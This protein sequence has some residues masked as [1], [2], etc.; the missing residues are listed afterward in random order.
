MQ[1]RVAS[2]LL[3]HRA[4]E[5][6]MTKL[7]AIAVAFAVWVTAGLAAQDAASSQPGKTPQSNQSVTITGCVEGGPNNTFTLVAAPETM[8][9]P[10]TGTTVTTPAGTKVTKTITYTLIGAKPEELKPH[11]GHTVQVSG[12]E[13][14]PQATAQGTQ[15]STGAATAGTT[16]T[17]PTGARATVETTAQTQIVVRQLTVSSVKMVSDSCRLTPRP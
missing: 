8:K 15:V 10:A 3:R 6:D 14:G 7:S 17:N 16:G 13:S 12:A 2:I 11:V 5:D 9:E 4:P 1:R